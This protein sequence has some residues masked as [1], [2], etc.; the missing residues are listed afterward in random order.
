[1]I[2]LNFQLAA[3]LARLKAGNIG[4]I[5]VIIRDKAGREQVMTAGDLVDTQDAIHACL[6]MAVKLADAPSEALPANNASAG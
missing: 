3:L 6:R 4:G 5:A 1:M 2:I